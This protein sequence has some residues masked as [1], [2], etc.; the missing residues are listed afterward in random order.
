VLVIGEPGLGKSRLVRDWQA[1]EESSTD[2]PPLQ[3]ARGGC[4]SDCR[5]EAY[6]LL[7]YLVRSLLGVSLAASEPET[8]SALLSLVQELFGSTEEDEGLAVYAFLGHLLSVELKGTVLD[9]VQHANPQALRA[10]YLA[11]LRQLLRALAAR[12]SMVLILENLH[13]A[14]PSS[15]DLLSQLL[16]LSSSAPL[17]FCLTTRPDRDAPG[18]RMVTA[19]REAMGGSLVELMLD[20]LAEPASRQLLCNLLGPH[21]LPEHVQALVLAKAEGKQGVVAAAQA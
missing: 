18:W 4:S 9:R 8:R 14:D 21:L 17:L 20:A 2:Q 3:W 11:A 10:Q 7:L 19:A 6:Y 12:H 16:S 13:W 1:A 15:V 5:E